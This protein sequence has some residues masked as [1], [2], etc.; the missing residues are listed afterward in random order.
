[1][2][3]QQPYFVVRLGQGQTNSFL[4]VHT[5]T[6]QSSRAWHTHSPT[7]FV[8][9]SNT[10]TH[11]PPTTK[12]QTSEEASH[13]KMSLWIAW[14]VLLWTQMETDD[15]GRT[16]WFEFTISSCM[17]T[18]THTHQL[19][20]TELAHSI[21]W[22]NHGATWFTIKSIR[23]MFDHCVGCCGCRANLHLNT[24]LQWERKMNIKKFQRNQK[25]SFYGYETS[26]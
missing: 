6:N 16:P 25:Q 24:R 19:G 15:G 7:Q 10:H 13:S 9:T 12:S 8:Y 2:K 4:L 20:Y 3:R 14:F 17:I 22:R 11:P 26:L 23:H 5:H 18:N 21:F 1:M